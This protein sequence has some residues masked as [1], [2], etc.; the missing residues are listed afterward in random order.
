MLSKKTRVLLLNSDYQPVDVISW[1]KC[2]TKLYADKPTIYV[3]NHYDDQGFVD[4]K[5]NLHPAPAVIVS[6]V[7]L[8]INSKKA[9]YTK[10]N[11][12]ARD[13]FTCQYC[14]QRFVVSELTV[15]HIAPKS[16]FIEK[17]KATEYKNITTACKPCNS[18]KA[19]IPLG[20]A[21]YPNSPKEKW[22]KKLAGQLI[23]LHKTPTV[24]SRSSVFKKKLNHISV[25]D[26]WR[27]YL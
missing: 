4:G 25:P 17:I 1:K 16:K 27:E 5:G 22:L 20:K 6:K 19:D 3:I 12:F 21:R 8:D 23:T 24:P 13:D 9:P 2:I 11:V 10:L 7:Y 26:E 14:M 15:D 18:Y